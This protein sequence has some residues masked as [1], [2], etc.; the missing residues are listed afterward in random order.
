MHNFVDL[1]RKRTGRD[2]KA[3]LRLPTSQ[4]NMLEIN[5]LLSAYRNNIPSTTFNP[6]KTFDIQ[7]DSLM[8]N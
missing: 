8:K 6:Y 4:R 1:N 7:I 3:H 2:L 5:K